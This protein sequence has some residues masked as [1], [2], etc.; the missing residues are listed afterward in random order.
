MK[1]Y[2]KKL[3]MEQGLEIF[4]ERYQKYF[5]LVIVSDEQQI[6]ITSEPAATEVNGYKVCAGKV[7]LKAS[8]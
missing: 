6:P 5:E 1:D 7:P 8:S 3:N 2:F 4:T